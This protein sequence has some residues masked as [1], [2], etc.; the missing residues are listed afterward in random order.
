[1]MAGTGGVCTPWVAAADLAGRPDLSDKHVDAGVITQA[2]L[3]ASNLL[4]ALSGRQ[5]AG[6]CTAV[7]RPYSNHAGVRGLTPE[8]ADRTAL[9]STTLAFNGGVCWAGIRLGVYPI[10]SITQIKIDGAVVNPSQYRV[11]DS[12]WL[13]RRS[14]QPWPVWQQ[15]ELD[16]TQ[17][18]T[19]SVSVS[20]GADP[21]PAGFSA[22]SALG[23]EFAKS[24]AGLPNRLPVRLQTITRQGVSMTVVDPMSFLKDGFTGIL[25]ADLFIRAYNPAKQRRRPTV[26]SPDL[27]SSHRM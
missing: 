20:Y 5:Y 12:R 26:W 18:G 2:A 22:A 14:G 17:V 19:F 25:E 7:L 1:L 9:D 11:D 3:D 8:L 4:Y 23:A 13:V 6:T 16:D 27:E 15:L 24:R 10:R 21:P